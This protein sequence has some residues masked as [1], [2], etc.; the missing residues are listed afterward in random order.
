[1]DIIEETNIPLLIFDLFILPI[2]L[3]RL[4]LIYFFGSRYNIVG[5]KFL[6]V[7]LHA[8]NKYFNKDNNNII[9]TINDDFRLVLNND[10]KISTIVDFKNN[11]SNQEKNIMKTQIPIKINDVIET[12][13]II[14][15]NNNESDNNWEL[16]NDELLNKSIDKSNGNTLNNN[17]IKNLMTD[18]EE[19]ETDTDIDTD[20]EE[21]DDFVSGVINDDSSNDSTDDSSDNISNGESVDNIENDDS[22]ENEDEEIDMSKFDLDN[23]TVSLE[24]FVANDGTDSRDDTIEKGEDN[25]EDD[26][27]S[28][29]EELNSAIL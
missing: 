24:N 3:L 28:L 17:M 18:E 10:S 22:E 6:D 9:D 7:M 4:G 1:M 20:E 16:S 25:I 27:D 21:S 8:S 23:I 13:D 15:G 11:I 26:L 12:N 29:V 5:F 14:S 2:T 19:T